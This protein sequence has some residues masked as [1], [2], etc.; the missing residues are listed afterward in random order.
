MALRNRISKEMK[1]L[2]KLNPNASQK[3]W[4][5][6]STSHASTADIF[7]THANQLRFEA[8][9]I[10]SV[11]SSKRRFSKS[12][13]RALLATKKKRLAEAKYRDGR[14]KVYRKSSALY[15]KMAQIT[16]SK[17]QK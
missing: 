10:Q 13:I 1:H 11:V 3:E 12:T 8:S 15:G 14:I 16:K 4:K 5:R 7:Q 17:K 9:A 6:W 2:Q